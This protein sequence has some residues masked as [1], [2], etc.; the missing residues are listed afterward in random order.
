MG[1][2]VTLLGTPPSLPPPPLSVPTPL[3]TWSCHRTESRL[4]TDSGFSDQKKFPLLAMIQQSA[5][6]LLACMWM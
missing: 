1:C 6:N 4:V 5:S 3:P 2:Q